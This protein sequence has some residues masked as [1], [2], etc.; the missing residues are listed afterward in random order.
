MKIIVT[1]GAGFIG[2]HLC[3]ALVSEGHNVVCVDNFFTGK[4]DSIAHLMGASNFQLLSHDILT[5]LSMSA[6]QI[7]H[8][9]CPASPIHY[10]KDPIKTVKTAFMG[11]LNMLELAKK[12][13]A[14]F[15]LSSTSEIYGDPSVHPQTESYWGNVNPIGVRSCYNEGKRISESLCFDFYRQYQIDL[16]VVRIFNTYGPRMAKDDGRVMGNFV[17][18]ALNN[19]PITVNGDGGQ[20]RSFCFVKD[21]VNGLQKMMNNINQFTGPVNLGRPE[22][23]T[24]LELANLIINQIGSQSEI[25]YYDLPMDD[26][27]RR[28]PDISLAKEKLGWSPDT[29]IEE[30][31]SETIL[32][33]KKLLE[34]DT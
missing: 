25:K 12:C 2:S 17:M 1:G 8:L 28:L 22:E 15:L 18:Q 4:N 5:P 26:P 3:E 9:A 33:Y 24:I 30:G 6:D 19:E 31:L 10:Q 20:T 16:R 13:G 29:S 7:Y 34:S 32:Y 11:T 23:L 14:R 27:K 21:T